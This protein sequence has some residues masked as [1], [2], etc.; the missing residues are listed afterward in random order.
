MAI[1]ATRVRNGGGYRPTWGGRSP[2]FW[3]GSRKKKKTFTGYSVRKGNGR[4]VG[5]AGDKDGMGL[6]TKY[7]TN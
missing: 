6:K 1:L 2:K 4:D 5:V 7:R 3:G